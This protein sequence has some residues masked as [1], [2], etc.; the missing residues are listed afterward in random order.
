MVVDVDV[1]CGM[2][3][4]NWICCTVEVVS[5]QGKLW[6]LGFGFGVFYEIPGVCWCWGVQGWISEGVGRTLDVRLWKMWHVLV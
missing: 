4:G 2:Y 6:L 5:D 1:E 3:N